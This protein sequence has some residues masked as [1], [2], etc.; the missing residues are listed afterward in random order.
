M[1][2]YA[3]GADTT[4]STIRSFFLA[5]A[6]NPDVFRK[7]REEIDAVVG[8]QRLPSISD[9][10]RLP[11]INALICE[12]FR[13]AVVAPNGA[14]HKSNQD[15]VH[16]GY[17]IPKGSIILSNIQ[18]MMNDP[19]LYRDPEHFM[20]ER[21]LG[22]NPERD[23]REMAFG[24][25]R[26]QC[27]GRLL[28]EDTVFIA[29]AMSIAVFDIQKKIRNGVVVEPVRRM[30]PGFISHHEPYEIDVIPRSAQAATLVPATTQVP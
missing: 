10:F 27:P 14:P 30:K 8:T 24:F 5:M 13:W 17:F 3:G 25:G 26:R 28:A 2:I 21:F 12:L 22:K 23:P 29:C 20:P 1:A 6:L 4:V 11:Y 9:K 7:A 18:F 15:D 19:R 16:A